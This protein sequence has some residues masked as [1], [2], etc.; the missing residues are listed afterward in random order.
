MAD[1]D[2]TEEQDLEDALREAFQEAESAAD[3][4]SAP[5][6]VEQPERED[7]AESVSE[8]DAE[9]SETT[10]EDT[11]EIDEQPALT[12]PED[13]PAEMRK[14]FDG[15]TDEAA[16][17]FVLESATK[18]VEPLR[19]QLQDATAKAEGFSR[20]EGLADAFEPHMEQLQLAG[21]TPTSWVNQMIAAQNFLSRDPAGALQHLA[22]SYGVDLATLANG[23]ADADDT[24]TDPAMKQVSDRL[25]NIETGLQTWQQQQQTAQTQDVNAQI[26]AFRDAKDDAGNLQH[27]HFEKLRAQMSGLMQ[28]GATQDMQQA[29]DM[30]MWSDPE[31]RQQL[32]DSQKA[33][34]EQAAKA[35]QSKAAQAAKQKATKP[36][37]TQKPAKTPSTDKKDDYSM[38]SD[39]EKD[40][41]DAFNEAAEA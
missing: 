19:T 28:S 30:A 29:Y 38:T 2:K 18:L 23:E 40:L 16:R 7:A 11:T 15:F 4:D 31:L 21:L 27:P 1:D 34:A 13:W 12:A 20:F 6:V 39:L 36:T 17:A 33:E 37:A 32:L 9:A 26:A 10:S 3:G 35:E 24:F 8:G 14:A 22:R 25:S 41:R 5:E